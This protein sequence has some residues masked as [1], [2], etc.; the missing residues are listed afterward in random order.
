L[1]E[2][3]LVLSLLVPVEVELVKQV[4]ILVQVPE[5]TAVM[6]YRHPLQDLGSLVL[7]EAV[8]EATLAVLAVAEELAVEVMVEQVLTELLEPLTLVAVAVEVL[9][10]LQV[11]QAVLAVQA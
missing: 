3:P 11:L 1:L 8:A 6:V 5:A 10:T 4:Q 9:V 2:V 7:V